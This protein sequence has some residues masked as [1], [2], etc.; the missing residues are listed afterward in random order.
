MKVTLTVCDVC[1]NQDKPAVTYEVRRVDDGLTVTKDLCAD[2][3]AVLE[4]LLA[5]ASI[6][7][8]AKSPRAT[9]PRAKASGTTD[10]APRRGRVMVT[11]MDEIEKQKAGKT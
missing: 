5:D 2:H 8:P 6:K 4:E 7:A 11:S 10:T 1:S 3:G 9:A